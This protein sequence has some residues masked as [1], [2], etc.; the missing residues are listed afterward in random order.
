MPTKVT[1]AVV[2]IAL[3]IS[4][5]GPTHAN[6]YVTFGLVTGIGLFT[7]W[8]AYRIVRNRESIV[9]TKTLYRI[10][11]SLDHDTGVRVVQQVIWHAPKKKRP[12]K[13][14]DKH[15]NKKAV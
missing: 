10:M 12:R 1:M 3:A 14:T 8:T 15:P 5:L 9:E 13:K 2:V 6:N 11:K 7:A 4:L